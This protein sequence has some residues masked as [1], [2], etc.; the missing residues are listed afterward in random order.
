[1]LSI[2]SVFQPKDKKFIEMK[3]NHGLAN[4]AGRSTLKH[5]DRRVNRE[6]QDGNTSAAERYQMLVNPAPPGPF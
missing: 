1:M 4:A 3:I 5:A 2:N 6:R